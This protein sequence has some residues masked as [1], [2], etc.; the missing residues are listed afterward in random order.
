MMETIC[1][2][3]MQSLIL[4]SG[5]HDDQRHTFTSCFVDFAVTDVVV[6]TAVFDIAIYVNRR[7]SLGVCF[8]VSGGGNCDAS[9]TSKPEIYADIVVNGR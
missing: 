9:S 7:T 3:M 2:I 1:H 8:S 4:P 5:Q 6:G